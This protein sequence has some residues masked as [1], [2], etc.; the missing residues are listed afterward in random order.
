MG[1]W[2]QVQE[3]ANHISS[4]LEHYLRNRNRAT[5]ILLVDALFTTV[6]GE[7]TAAMIEAAGIPVKMVTKKLS[8]GHP[9]MI[10]VIERGK[11]NGVINT[12]TGAS[13]PLRD[14]FEIRRAAAE[15][16]IPCFTSLDTARVAAEVLVNKCQ[17]Y[18]IQPLKD[19]LNK[20]QL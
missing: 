2:K 15:R 4:P 20:S 14:G 10:D 1:K 6:K 3:Y 5:H 18:N 12:V 9:D 19:Y 7:G 13:I 8:E 17:T 11:V 16:R